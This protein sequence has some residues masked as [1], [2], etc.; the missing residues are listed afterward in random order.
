VVLGA[1]VIGLAGG[2]EDF[3][4]AVER[5]GFT[6]SVAGL[7]EQGQ[8]LLEV[9]GGLLVATLPKVGDAEV[10]QR[11]G[12]TG[13]VAGVAVQ[14]QGAAVVACGLLVAALP[15]V[16]DAEVGQRFRFGGAVARVAGGVPGAGVDSDGLGVVAA[17]IEVAEQD[18]GQPGGVAGPAVG[19]GVHRD[20]DQAGSLAVQPGPRRGRAG[21]RRGGVA[22]RGM[23]GRR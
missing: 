7:A 16:D 14:G 13:L 10:V 5:L 23:R 1:G 4:D 20:R 15:P 9:T 12:R 22:S 3:A 8:G 6:G 19:G 18:G 11:A 2:E 21:H 17:G